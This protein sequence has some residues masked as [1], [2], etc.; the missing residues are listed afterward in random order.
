MSVDNDI[1]LKSPTS[2]RQGETGHHMR[3]VLGLSLAGV[4]AAFILVG[5]FM[6]LT[7]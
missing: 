7:Q 3:Y 6:G 4:I 1:T 5:T 2:A